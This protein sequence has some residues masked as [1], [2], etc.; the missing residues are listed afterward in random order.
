MNVLWLS[1]NSCVQRTDIRWTGNKQILPLHFRAKIFPHGLELRAR[2]AKTRRSALA[3]LTT[4]T[5]F[6]QNLPARTYVCLDSIGTLDPVPDMFSLHGAM[7][8]VLAQN[9]NPQFLHLYI[10]QE[11]LGGNSAK[12]KDGMSSLL[13][14]LNMTAKGL[15]APCVS[16]VTQTLARIHRFQPIPLR[17][18]NIQ[19]AKPRKISLQ[20][21][22]HCV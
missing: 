16:A 3:N 21:T 20:F 15:R 5:K 19:C 18:V 22:P 2:N 9:P 7:N 10:I 8:I 13:H 12:G 17:K 4:H 1:R 6:G 14:L 11:R